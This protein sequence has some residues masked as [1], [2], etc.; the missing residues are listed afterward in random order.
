MTLIGNRL[1]DGPQDGTSV[2]HTST[3][4]ATEP[5]DFERLRQFKDIHAG[6]RV[7]IL[8]NGPSLNN[9]DLSFLAN[10]IVF[11]M[12]KIY[13]GF[14][15]FGFYPR[16]FVAVDDLVLEQAHNE[17]AKI[18]C[19]KFVTH[20]A[21][22]FLPATPLTFHMNTDHG[23]PERFYHDITSGVREGH[24]VMHA[25]LQ[26]ARYM[27]F[28]EVVIIGM[29]HRFKTQSGPNQVTYMAGPDPNHFTDAY[30]SGHNWNGPNLIQAERS[31]AAARAAFEAEG[32]RIIDATLDGACE[33]FE[34]A[35]YR[36]V[37][38]INEALQAD[39]DTRAVRSL[40]QQL[41]AL[42][43]ATALH[44]DVASTRQAELDKVYVSLSWRLTE[45]LRALR[46]KLNR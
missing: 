27:G 30:F 37:F 14:E 9:M 12:N 1:Q 39:P 21:A 46:R 28:S 34:K 19:I 18:S 43:A 36:A 7:V 8:G 23:L 3:K 6:Q 22:G 15:K 32:K 38:G 16:Y 42:A 13:L 2:K 35:D 17:I 41:A 25:T 5:V 31:Y 20:R 29:D 11:G 24:T 40:R 10:E 26:I 4:P 44:H 45:P 33:V